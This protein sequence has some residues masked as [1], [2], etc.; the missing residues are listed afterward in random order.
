LPFFAQGILR[1]RNSRY[2][3][4]ISKHQAGFLAYGS[5]Y[6]PHLPGQRFG[7]SGDCGFRPR[8]QRRDRDGIEPS[9]LLNPIS[10]GYLSLLNIKPHYLY[11]I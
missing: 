9:S 4:K 7:A 11:L 8:I 6:S 2:Y 5:I 1:S 3:R 10:W